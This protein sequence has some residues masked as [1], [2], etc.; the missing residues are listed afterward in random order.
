MCVCVR[1]RARAG[2]CV[3]VCTRACVYVCVYN[4]TQLYCQV[5]L[6]LDK[7]LVAGL[8]VHDAFRPDR[9]S[10]VAWALNIKSNSRSVTS[11]SNNKQLNKSEYKSS[12]KLTKRF[13]ASCLIVF[14]EGDYSVGNVKC[15]SGRG[16]TV[17]QGS[18]AYR[19]ST[20]SLMIEVETVTRTLRCTASRG[21][22]QTTHAIIITD[23]IGLLQ[24]V[25]SGMGSPDWRDSVFDIHF[26]NNNNGNL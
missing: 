16:F 13:D 3:C 24:K 14:P 26:N 25:R 18:A 23:S 6:Q 10:V 5:S 20:S 19:V 4:T 9:T 15:Q 21:D 17:E 7:P 11:N 12:T 22:S 1:A 8:L 2:V